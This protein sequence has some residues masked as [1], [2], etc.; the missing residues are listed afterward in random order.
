MAECSDKNCQKRMV[1]LEEL[2]FKDQEGGV[3]FDIQ[4]IKENLRGVV[5]MW[6]VWV[7]FAAMLFAIVPTYVAVART[8]FLYTPIQETNQLRDRVSRLEEKH[9]H[10][11]TMMR[12]V[13]SE[14]GEI[15]HELQKLSVLMAR[16]DSKETKRFEYDYRSDETVELK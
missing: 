10:L 4:R 8:V 14:N 3:R 5:K 11:V 16:Q 13:R 1:N 12:E 7:V 6:Q 15:L 2:M 9:D